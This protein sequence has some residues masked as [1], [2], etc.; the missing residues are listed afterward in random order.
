M[1]DSPSPLVQCAAMSHAPVALVRRSP[2]SESPDELTA[3]AAS[4]EL[5]RCE[6]EQSAWILHRW[7]LP[8]EPHDAVV[9]IANGSG[10]PL[11][12]WTSLRFE[13]PAGTDWC[14]PDAV[15][16][17]GRSVIVASGVAASSSVTIVVVLGPGPAASSSG[18]EAALDALARVIA[19]RVS[20]TPPATDTAPLSIA[21]AVAVERDR[22]TRDLTHHFAQ[23]LET[24]LTRLRDDAAHDSAR[25][26]HSATAE[27]SRALVD[28]RERRALWQQARRVDQ[29]FAVVEREI[30]DLARAAGVR[31]ECTLAEGPQQLVANTVLDAASW[32]TR[33]AVQNVTQHAD[34]TRGHIAWS[35]MDG[36][37]VLSIVDDGRGFDPQPAAAGGLRAMRR[38]AE[39]L[40]GSLQIESVAG[41][42]T[43]VRA[44]LRLQAENAVGVDES[45]AVLV[46]ALG[47]REFD[48][49]RLMAVGHR[50]R[51]IA[52]ELALSPHTVKFHVGNI[53]EKLGVR[54]RAEAAA[55]AFAAGIHPRPRPAS[56]APDA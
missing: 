55:V 39:S 16:A 18:T 51:D 28:L 8:H 41:W 45:A 1:D 19:A 36:E 52:S 53:F 17:L 11:S 38:R 24:I 4:S 35:V 54:T 12:Q 48:V 50:N 6:L 31:L 27:A 25:R 20:R 26:I 15:R 44:V 47:D 46:R 9:V 40:G 29:A 22:L 23:H 14:S 42:G 21:H 2:A 37:L 32:I 3:L 10:E 49:L 33:A 56:S 43:Q 7:L 13:L 30:G 34:A 5:S